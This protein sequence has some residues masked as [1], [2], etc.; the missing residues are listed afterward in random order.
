MA[1]K[2]KALDLRASR[3]GIRIT[4][5]TGRVGWI[6]GQDGDYLLFDSENDA[7][8]ALR[9]MKKDARYSWNCTAEVSVFDG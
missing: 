6:V 3:Y 8:K 5:Q 7:A 1:R 2:Q 9:K 4:D